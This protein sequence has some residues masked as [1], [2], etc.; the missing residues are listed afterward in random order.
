MHVE[1][2]P[3]LLL[4]VSPPGGQPVDL[5]GMDVKICCF[6][7]F[8]QVCRISFCLSSCFFCFLQSWLEC[9][10][11]HLRRK[12]LKTGSLQPSGENQL[13]TCRKPW[14][15]GCISNSLTVGVHSIRHVGQ[16]TDMTRTVHRCQRSQC[17]TSAP[18]VDDWSLMETSC[19]PARPGLW[20][21]DL[22][23][24]P[25]LVCWYSIYHS[26]QIN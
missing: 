4:V 13:V 18:L 1:L 10:L 16:N 22:E 6:K 25:L 2:M 26:L 11:W 7:V 12:W 20:S 15:A 21:V 3:H 17:K 14:W 23:S 5:D 24:C 9:N 8:V 19:T